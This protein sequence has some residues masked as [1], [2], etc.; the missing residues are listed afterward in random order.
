MSGSIYKIGAII[1]EQKKLLVVRKDVPGGTEW[2]MPGGK[3]EGREKPF[4]TLK[5]ELREELQ[6]EVVR[7][8]FFGRFKETAVFEGVPLL[9]DAYVVVVR[10][11]P[12]PSSEITEC[13]LIDRSYNEKGVI[14]G[15][16]LE[17]LIVPR[18]I[19]EGLM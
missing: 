16:V 15:A 7:A 12:T 6:L 17:K 18:L 8:S 1:T 14:L 4:E 11:V 3:P 5:R 9:V 2:I 13:T 19:S 10:G